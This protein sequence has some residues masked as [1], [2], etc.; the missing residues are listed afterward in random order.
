MSPRLIIVL[1]LAAIIAASAGVVTFIVVQTDPTA[2]S[3]A[4]DTST[5]PASDAK[6]HDYREKFF[7]GDADRNIRDGQEMKP[8]W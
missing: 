2:V 6:R 7:S 1:A 5:K 4:Q 3:G 8:R